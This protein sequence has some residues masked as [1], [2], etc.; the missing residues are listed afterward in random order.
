MLKA[1]LQ[2]RNADSTLDLNTHLS[3]F[4]KRGIV[5]GGV[6]TPLTPNSQPQ[7]TVSPFKL[8]GVD[9]MAV[10]E[11]GATTTLNLPTNQTSVVCLKTKYSPNSLPTIEWQVLE[12]SAYNSDVD[13]DFLVVFAAVTTTGATDAPVVNLEMRDVIDAVGRP[14]IRG[15][16]TSYLSLPPTDN[17]LGDAYVIESG[18]SDPLNGL[19]VWKG[20]Q[21]WVNITDALSVSNLLNQHR[22]NLLSNEIHLTDAQA[23]AVL[24]T[25]GSPS[26][27][28]RFVT[29]TDPRVPTQTENDALV[30]LS[31]PTPV[32]PSNTNP[33]VTAA[34]VQAAPSSKVVAS[35]SPY[36]ALSLG[37]GP[38]YVGQAA[39]S[40]TALQYFK[41]F[42]VSENREYVNSA[43]VAVQITDIYKSI[44]PVTALDPSTEA[45]VAQ[46]KG[47]YNGNIWLDFSG[48]IDS[49]FRVMYGKQ[50]DFSN[51]SRGA[52][53]AQTPNDAQT[54]A[55]TLE[56]LQEISG[57]LFDDPM[58]VGESNVELA[59]G[60]KNQRRYLNVTTTADMVA[61]G[62]IFPKL[63][64][65]TDIAADF[66]LVLGQTALL[67]TAGLA[68]TV[69]Y[70]AAQIA[71]F[72]PGYTEDNGAV[73]VI[74]Y[75]SNPDL[76]AVKSGHLFVDDLGQEFRIL[77]ANAAAF[78]ILIYTQGLPVN[79]NNAGGNQSQLLANN[80]PRKIEILRDHQTTFGREF[81]PVD[82]VMQIHNQFEALPPGGVQVGTYE[83]VDNFSLI[84]TSALPNQGNATGAPTG[85]PIFYVTPSHTGNRPDP[86]VILVGNWKSDQVNNPRQALG[87]FSQGALG[88][89]Y[90]GRIQDITLL[91][92][93]RPSMPYGFRVFINGVYNHAAS[94][95]LTDVEYTGLDPSGAI[96]SLRG[97][98]EAAMQPLYFPLGLSTSTINTVRIEITEAGSSDFPLYGIEVFTPTLLEE[99]GRAFLGTDLAI[100]DSVASVSMPLISAQR[101]ARVTRYIDRAGLSRQTA[102]SYPL[103]IQNSSTG[104]TVASASTT[105]TDTTIGPN[106]NPGD[107][108]IF[109][110]RSTT[111]TDPT[112]Y[113][114]RM[115]TAVDKGTGQMT[116][117]A[118]LGFNLTPPLTR[119]ELAF[120]LPCSPAGAPVV[121][122]PFSK[123]DREYATLNLADWSVGLGRDVAGLS[124]IS[125]DSRVTTLDDGSTSLLVKACQQV[126]TGIQGFDK[127]VELTLTTSEMVM[128]AWATRMD[129]VFSG[130]GGVPSTLDIEIDGQFTYTI[131]LPNDGLV[132]HT[133]YYDAAPQT[134]TV[135]IKNP[136]VAGAV[137]VS[138]W[139]FHDLKSA[140]I[141]G[142]LISEFDVGR[143]ATP[144]SSSFYDFLPTGINNPLLVS[145]AGVRLFDITK[146]G[147]RIYEGTTGS[148]NWTVAQDFDL[149]PAYSY[150]LSTDRLNA[151]MEIQVVGSHFE[152][153]YLSG[154]DRGIA[155][156]Y[157]NGVAASAANFAGKV[158][159][160]GYLSGPG[161]LDQYSA[162]NNQVKRLV[163]TALPFARY[164]IRFVVTGTQNI[165]STST[166]FNLT[167]AAE[168][169]GS[170]VTQRR[171]LDDTAQNRL[172][173]GSYLDARQFLT[174]LPE[175]IGVVAGNQSS[176]SG[177]SAEPGYINSAFCYSD[178]SGTPNNCTVLDDLG[179][180]CVDV[181]WPYVLGLNPGETVGDLDVELNGVAIPR[182]VAGV[183]AG[184]W[185]EE[186]IVNVGRIKFWMI[187]SDTARSIRIK[188]KFGTKDES[189]VNTSRL[190]AYHGS[191][192]V[193]ST[194]QVQAGIAFYDNLQNAINA[195]PSGG[196]IEMLNT[197]SIGNI[198]VNKRVTIFG[199]GVGSQI[200]GTMT[201]TSA[202]VNSVI[203]DVYITGNVSFQ[204]SS[205]GNR[206]DGYQTAASTVTDAGVDNFYILTDV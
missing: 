159:G 119:A 131:T 40:S 71:A 168:N 58:Q 81:I 93:I 61:P 109:T 34:Y 142:T 202:S 185:W 12:I 200:T 33:Y 54:S 87:E 145:N 163:L 188:R 129:L 26:N 203:R 16:L 196:F 19:Y 91:T 127:A 173:Y 63:R 116:M 99:G 133:L 6:V 50:L 94:Q 1:L 122:A 144:A 160:A 30:G 120:R 83:P 44:G 27:T 111:P 57:R 21:G 78:Q 62:T 25:F 205:Q 121:A 192:V 14:N 66:P 90:T 97:T 52:M 140:P 169:S 41:L 195:A 147:T 170:G 141:D 184:A 176:S 135:R 180:T 139:I 95:F 13:I 72:D 124:S 155:Q 204:A 162:A 134:H 7:V 106:A 18:V 158:F 100:I 68:Y 74:T 191:L 55:E 166:M 15:T 206:L 125:L 2:F 60:H 48:T 98:E 164:V 20:N 70:L 115:L 101:G 22:A 46:T 56:R 199:R 96:A 105:F 123:F 172:H 113:A 82:G 38:F 186:D 76:T 89:E 43:G 79:V 114:Y 190:A 187:L 85:R 149:N 167:M 181:T 112:N 92:A 9:G 179:Q 24:G 148:Q 32:A 102:Y 31:Q 104:P 103:T 59:E 193:G 51:I 153:Y 143:N 157:I 35:A 84:S 171:N 183:T 29:D 152:F 146:Y 28:N 17:R 108:M 107:V 194:A 11:T 110:D 67:A 198:T 165:S 8:M 75:T 130:S 197:T 132:R 201:F 69:E 73:A 36:I 150:I 138:Q 42:H 65:V 64:Q 4:F 45:N 3:E 151:T 118:T 136:S 128:T 154:P 88:I 53:L 178:G 39:G 80:N 10:I 182:Y 126:S 47:F 49:Q 175:Q 77:A 23:D 177:E 174:L 86:R 156:V 5:S 189:A 37:D 161:Q 117:N 137:K